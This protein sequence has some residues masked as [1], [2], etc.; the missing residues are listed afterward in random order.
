MNPA[1][2]LRSALSKFE[3]MP[4]CEA[5]VFGPFAPG[6]G[7]RARRICHAGRGGPAPKIGRHTTILPPKLKGCEKR[8]GRL[9]E[10]AARPPQGKSS[11]SSKSK[12]NGI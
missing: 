1:K 2:K 6:I 11:K 3:K 8:A 4:I 10:E 5:I 7:A 12:T 9:K